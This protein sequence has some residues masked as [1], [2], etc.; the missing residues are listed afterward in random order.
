MMA[1]ATSHGGMHLR[2]GGKAGKVGSTKVRKYRPRWPA[3]MNRKLGMEGRTPP[4]P[5]IYLHRAA[6]SSENISL[7]RKLTHHTTQDGKKSQAK[8]KRRK[9]HAKSLATKIT[10]MGEKLRSREFRRTAS[11]AE[12]K[13]VEAKIAD[14]VEKL[15]QLESLIERTDSEVFEPSQEPQNDAYDGHN[16]IVEGQ[17]AVRSQSKKRTV[18]RWDPNS[19]EE[20]ETE[21]DISGTADSTE[22][23]LNEVTPV[24][25]KKEK[26]EKKD[27]RHK[28]RKVDEPP[29][30]LSHPLKSIPAFEQAEAERGADYNNGNIKSRKTK[31]HASKDGENIPQNGLSAPSLE[32]TRQE[33]LLDTITR[34][35]ARSESTGDGIYEALVAGML[36]QPSPPSPMSPIADYPRSLIDIGRSALAA[37]ILPNTQKPIRDRAFKAQVPVPAPAP[38]S[39]PDTSSAHRESPILPPVRT[40]STSRIVP[41][42][43]HNGAEKSK[44]KK[45][46][47]GKD[48]NHSKSNSNTNREPA[49][50]ASQENITLSQTVTALKEAA[51]ATVI[52]GIFS[53]ADPFT[54]TKKILPPAKSYVPAAASFPNSINS[55][56]PD[57]TPTKSKS[58]S[59][60]RQERRIEGEAEDWEKASGRF[61]ARIDKDGSVDDGEVEESE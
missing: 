8:T 3:N 33:A 18:S 17:V 24:R 10:D 27:K 28:K 25:I 57:V 46:T 19:E 26:T 20:A 30:N 2:G 15:R 13:I 11:A 21:G 61:R 50:E 52:E 55:S 44:S 6:K 39:K 38:A 42:P 51:S 45:D 43:K 35:R 16:P 1:E 34:S 59:K 48:A 5:R 40:F 7:V 12:V 14:R 49:V 32:K 56:T 37:P 60:S 47:H 58:K 53:Q 29:Q 31:S 54:G 36:A 4:A 9:K 23:I 22:V 41:L